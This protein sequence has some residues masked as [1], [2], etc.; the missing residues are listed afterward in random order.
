M[1]KILAKSKLAISLARN[2]I[3]NYTRYVAVRHSFKSDKKV[4][5]YLKDFRH[6]PYY[7]PILFAYKL[8][9]YE[10]YL[11]TD[12]AFIA[13]TFSCMTDVFSWEHLKL[14]RPEAEGYI[15][16]TDDE[17]FFEKHKTGAKTKI[18]IKS[19]VY[20]VRLKSNFLPFPMHPNIYKNYFFEKLSEH[21]ILKRKIRVLFSG[22]TSEKAYNNEIFT[23][24]FH[25]LNR[26]E[27]IDHLIASFS[28]NELILIR[29]KNDLERSKSINLSNKIVLYKW[30]WYEGQHSNLQ[31]KIPHH[32]WL[33]FLASGDFFVCC[34][35]IRIPQSHN[36]IEAMAVGTIPILQYASFFHPGLVHNVNCIV[37]TDK[38]DLIEKIT[39]I[40]N[41]PE[42]KIQ[43]MKANVIKYYELYLSYTNEKFF[44]HMTGSELYIYN[45]KGFQWQ[46]KLN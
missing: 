25:I 30:E 21:R 20:N 29:N 36:A 6:E 13:N 40:L 39:M 37:F 41:M 44:E 33:S 27:I 45:E 3:K 4:F 18:I 1:K 8:R 38:D 5:F 34:P 43:E 11:Y 17:D 10:I 2:L 42:D 46:K 7:Y 32:E 19:D 22:N 16:I 26:I 24:F 14:G 9:D 12:L 31:I 23:A 28:S 35:G 15:L